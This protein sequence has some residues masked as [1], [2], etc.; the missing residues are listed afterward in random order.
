MAEVTI[1]SGVCGFSTEVRTRRNGKRCEVAVES[2]CKSIQRLAAELKEVEPFQEIT[3][4]GQGPATLR[5]AAQCGLHPACPVP[6]G[7]IKAVEVECRLAAPADAFITVRRTAS[8]TPETP[9]PVSDN[10]IEI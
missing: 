1:M 3:Y 4:R 9:S 7:I 2:Q 5:A 6:S 10:S 8:A